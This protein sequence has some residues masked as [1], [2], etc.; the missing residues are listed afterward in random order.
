MKII[1]IIKKELAV[2][3]VMAIEQEPKILIII[4]NL[5]V[6]NLIELIG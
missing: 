5:Y 4:Y 6:S 2:V 1:I 3:T